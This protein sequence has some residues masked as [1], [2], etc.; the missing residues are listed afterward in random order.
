MSLT[1]PSAYSNSSKLG[2]IQENWIAQ[3]FHQNSYLSFDGTD[4][5]IDLGATTDASAMCLDNSD[6]LTVAFW[7]NFPTRDANE[8]IFANNSQTND[9]S[10]V[11]VYKDSNNKISLGW[12]DGSGATS[13]DRE[14]MLGSTALATDTWYFIAITTDF[15]L[16]TT[17]TVIRV[18]NS[19]ETVANGGTSGATN[20]VNE[21]GTA[22]F[23]RRGNVY[24]EFK[25][26]NFGIWSGELDSNNLTAL[27]NSGNYFSF[28]ENSGNYTQA[29]ALKGYWEFNNGEN[30]IQDKSG[31]G[32]N[33]SI[34]GGIYKD[35]LPLALSDATIDDVFYHGVITNKPSIRSSINLS[36]STAKTG[37]MSLS[38]ANAQYKGD[39]LSAELFLGTRKYINRGV[40]IYSQLNGDTTL[41]NCLQVYSGRLID[42]SHDVNSISLNIVERRPW[43]FISIPQDT[44]T[45]G[46]YFPVVY[47]NFTSNTSTYDVPAYTATFSKALHPVEVDAHSFYYYCLNHEDTGSTDKILH[48]YEPGLDAFVPLELSYDAESYSGG[49]TL[50][51]DWHLKRHFKFKPTNAI[52][53]TFASVDNII[54]GTADETSSN[55]GTTLAMDETSSAASNILRKDN[56]FNLPSLDD[57]PDKQSTSDNHGFTIE[58]RWRMDDIEGNT[59]NSNGLTVNKIEILDNGRYGGSTSSP[60]GITDGTQFTTAGTFNGSLTSGTQADIAEVT[61]SI[62]SATAYSTYGGYEDGLT[63]RFKRTVTSATDGSGG[64]TSNI[65]G[66][67]IVYDLRLKV[68]LK[69]DKW[70]TTTDGSARVSSVKQ[71]YSGHD[72]FAKSFSGGSGTASTGLEAHRDL[73][74]RFAGWDDTNGNIYNYDDNLDIE[75][76]RVT[77]AW[78]IRWWENKPI[79]L[80]KILEQIQKEFCF[81]FKFRHDGSGSY[82]Y[83]KNSYSSGDVAE[84]LK[85][86]DITNLKINNTPFSELLTKMEINYEKHPAES[87]Y[88]SNVTAVDATNNQRNTWNILAKEN[89]KKIDLDMNV[90]KPGNA[91]P[92]GGD[93]NDGFADYYMNIF[94]DVKKIISC[95]IINSA[96][97]YSLE[98]GD[99]VQFSN[100]AGDMPVDPFGDNWADYYMITTLNRSPGSVSITAREVG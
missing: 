42:I 6:D 93:P 47:G 41:A 89:I 17:N 31:N 7:I 50:K 90:N 99:I 60:D 9:Y 45:K 87:R 56:L 97:G 18:N 29:S 40:Q 24:G 30:I 34:T 20:P 12:G 1:L 2:N 86:D 65:E 59:S 71:L 77:S 95:D 37:N 63:I 10:G 85:K 80:K 27:Y 48:Y 4:D 52:A 49:F 84:T 21:S 44:S 38:I 92:G 58:C 94:G 15:S 43:D 54:D 91:N 3:L 76:V 46:N 67:L 51:T 83:I 100:T 23:G 11:F 14:T 33:G 73:L 8:W 79:E 88:I 32:A 96:K 78:N 39:D 98:T 81:I 75:A 57:M 28:T 19:A 55:T 68:T 26:K 82:W 53:K 61:S 35:Y 5:Y 66:D 62:N 64:Y 25:I 22:Y 74:N 72:G 16:T 69:I 13:G 70:N 36:D